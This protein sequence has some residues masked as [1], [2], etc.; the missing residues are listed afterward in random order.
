MNELVVYRSNL[1]LASLTQ[2]QKSI[3]HPYRNNAPSDY[4]DRM[5]SNVF[6]KYTQLN[7][8]VPRYSSEVVKMKRDGIT[9][10]YS[11]HRFTR[12]HIDRTFYYLTQSTHRNHIKTLFHRIFSSWLDMLDP[13]T[14][15][16]FWYYIRF[17]PE[18]PC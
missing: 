9:K 7:T 11:V 17:Y 16:H 6:W 10:P 18:Y 12:R 8:L 15:I 3:H 13:P 1:M 4:I 14:K 2:T 5:R